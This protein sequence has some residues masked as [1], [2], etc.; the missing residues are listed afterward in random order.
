MYLYNVTCMRRMQMGEM[1]ISGN[2]EYEL[3]YITIPIRVL[4]SPRRLDE[5][6]KTKILI[7]VKP[8]RY[9]L[10]Y[11]IAFQTLLLVPM[12]CRTSEV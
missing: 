10:L 5:N 6:A 7:L 1:V 3:P 2:H 11:K 9:N 12:L 4:E 8:L